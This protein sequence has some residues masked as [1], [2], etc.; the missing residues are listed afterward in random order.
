MTADMATLPEL[1]PHDLE[2]RRFINA[3]AHLIWKCWTEAAHLKEWFAPKP[4]LITD[5]KI[6][7]R[8]GGQFTLTMK[9]PE[10]AE[11]P[12]SG[13]YLELIEN[14]RIA[15]TDCLQ[16]GW[17]PADNPFFSATVDMFEQDGGTHYIARALHKDEAGR[18]THEEMG[19]HDGWGTVIGQLAEMVEG[20]K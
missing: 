3:P 17:R 20:M 15:T 1:G 12:I 9:S 7:P 14:R 16:E 5:C 19:F 18:K 8:P 2:I 4:F 13:V 11:Y 6:D 10:G